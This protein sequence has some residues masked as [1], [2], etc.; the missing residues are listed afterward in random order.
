MFV[1]INLVN[2]ELKIKGT[3]RKKS[4]FSKLLKTLHLF[5]VVVKYKIKLTR[6][7]KNVHFGCQVYPKFDPYFAPKDE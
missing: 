4:K 3:Y 5:K 7:Y 2:Y 1:S 6:K